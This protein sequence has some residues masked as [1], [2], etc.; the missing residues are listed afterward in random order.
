MSA[1]KRAYKQQKLV[2]PLPQALILRGAAEPAR[3]IRNKS[4]P[5]AEC[6][7]QP[8]LFNWAVGPSCLRRAV[9]ARFQ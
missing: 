5:T 1:S 8:T 6:T 7:V 2:L 3:S 9:E 4:A